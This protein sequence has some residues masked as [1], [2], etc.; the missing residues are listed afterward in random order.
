MG[1]NKI[2]V[3][4]AGPDP[5]AET[6]KLLQFFRD[7]L[8]MA[9]ID[10]T[11]DIEDPT[12]SRKARILVDGQPVADTLFEPSDDGQWAILAFDVKKRLDG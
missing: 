6:K 4:V 12:S 5:Q 10:C 1:S 7:L 9:A 2:V 3:G 8:T 11:V